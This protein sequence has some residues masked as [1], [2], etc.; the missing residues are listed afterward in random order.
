[1]GRNIERIYSKP[2]TL[3]NLI[4]ISECQKEMSYITKMRNLILF[5]LSNREEFQYL[6]QRFHHQFWVRKRSLPIFRMC[7]S[8]AFF[9]VVKSHVLIDDCEP[10]HHWAI[11]VID[12]DGHQRIKDGLKMETACKN[13][14]AVPVGRFLVANNGLSSD[15]YP[16]WN[17]YP[18]YKGIIAG[19]QSNVFEQFYADAF[20]L[21]HESTWRRAYDAN[22]TF[23][24]C[25]YND[26]SLYVIEQKR[27]KTPINIFKAILE[28]EI[29]ICFN[30]KL[31]LKTIASPYY[32]ILP[33]QD[34]RIH[35]ENVRCNYRAEMCSPDV[36]AIELVC[37]LEMAVKLFTPF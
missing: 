26:F 5:Q 24:S 37:Q 21:R 34:E 35:D 36:I 1:M 25:E 22:L 13:I 31:V 3:L 23:F 14:N 29:G 30:Q 18:Y 10:F 4:K 27:D 2:S 15:S 9:Q 20:L 11:I 32:Y 7:Y 28:R 33:Y 6:D 8:H 19:I 17:F 12:N 16:N